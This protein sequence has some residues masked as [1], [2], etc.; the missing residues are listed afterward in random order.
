[1]NGREHYERS[2]ALLGGRHNGGANGAKTAEEAIALA[3]VHAILALA[4]ATLDARGA[5]EV[6]GGARK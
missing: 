1:M 3:Q 5:C 2:E 6:C 4:D